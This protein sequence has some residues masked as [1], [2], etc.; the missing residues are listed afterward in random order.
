MGL[1]L[2]RG[3]TKISDKARWTEI[4]KEAGSGRCRSVIRRETKGRDNLWGRRW[5]SSNEAES[6]KGG[7]KNDLFC[8]GKSP[9]SSAMSNQ[10]KTGPSKVYD[11]SS[12]ST[13]ICHNAPGRLRG[14]EEGKQHL[15]FTRGILHM[16]QPQLPSPDA[17]TDGKGMQVV[18]QIQERRSSEMVIKTCKMN[19][20]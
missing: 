15:G 2:R 6:E 20:W 10:T 1:L 14:K 12:L 8:S 18:W 9:F 13:L 7:V 19:K 17:P 11:H 16:I 3:K 4:Q 5:V